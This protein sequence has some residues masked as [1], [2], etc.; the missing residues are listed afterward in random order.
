MAKVAYPATVIGLIFSD[1]PGSH[2]GDV[3]SGPTYKDKSTIS[4]ASKI[5]TEN[6]LGEFDLLE[7]P[8]EDKYFE[9]VHNFVLVSNKTAIESMA[10]KAKEFDLKVSV[11]STEMYDETSIA[12]KKI[13]QMKDNNT[14]VLAAGEPK[15]EVKKRGG[16]GGR[17]LHMGLKAI[18]MGLIDENSVF[19]SLA[20][21]GMDNSDAAGAIVDYNTLE[22]LKKSNLSADDYLARFD[23]YT[24]FQ[25]LGDLVMTGPTGANVSDL[26]IL[27]TKK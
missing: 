17:N 22:E 8:K 16:I 11:L 13:F 2:F 4:D 5:I 6:N 26:M 7:T 23:S 20:S 27:L 9:K 21:D 25:K 18:Q 3:A 12:L 1:I 10:K 24:F 14:V 19:L 15:L